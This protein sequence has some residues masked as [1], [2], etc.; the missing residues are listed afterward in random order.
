MNITEALGFLREATN[1]PEADFRTDQW[2]AIDRVA[3]QRQKLLLVQRTGWGKSMVYFM[4]TKAIRDLGRGPTIII[5][6][7]LAL[8][9]NQIEAAGRIGIRATSVDSTNQQDWDRITR[10]ILQD[11]Y[12]AILISPERL[13]NDA[14]IDTVLLPIA[15]S[16]GLLVI[17]EAHCISI[18]GHDFR[19]DYR[20]IVNIIT[21][22]PSNMPVLCTTATANNIVVENIQQQ[23]GDIIVRRGPLRRESLILQNI[24]LNDQASRLAWL[25]HIIPTLEGTGIVY[26]LTKRDCDNVARWLNESGIS[27]AAYYAGVTHPDFR[28]TNEYRVYLEDQLLAD[29]FKVIVAT[30]SLGMGYDKPDLH[31]VIHFQTPDSIIG[32][33]QQVGRAGRAIPRAYGVLLAGREDTDIHAYFRKNAFP[34]RTNVETILRALDESDG[35]SIIQLQSLINLTKSQIENVLKYLRA[36][37]PSPVVK[38]GRLWK[39]TAVQFVM[40]EARITRI[41]ELRIAEWRDINSYIDN[42]STCLMNHLGNAL[43]DPESEDCGMCANCN[44]DHSLTVEFPHELGIRAATY[45]LH[46]EIPLHL[47]K[48][49]APDSFPNYGLRGNIPIPLR[50]EVGRILS[51]WGDAGWGH[52]VQHDK[53]ANHFRDELVDAMAEV[54]TDRWNPNPRPQWVTSVPSQRHPELVPDYARRLATK[55]GIPFIDI[56]EKTRENEAQKLQQNRFF[57]C[58]NLDGAFRV[59][60][61]VLNTP[62]LLV[63]DLVDSGWTLT[64][65]SILLLRAGSGPVYPIALG[66][67]SE[68]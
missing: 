63:D 66:S 17:D 4:A 34:N 21:R 10:E 61:G 28:N 31:F 32:Y 48:Q 19:P 62:V 16:V 26:A 29:N 42:F 50:G 54:I 30:T 27:A 18:W 60:E 64:V 55:L 7:L 5:S 56:I 15:E 65:L 67:T 46:A 1:N 24:R 51:R 9:R 11:H 33:Y 2:D 68:N 44:P 57:R 22:M 35:L 47:K 14:F 52:I 6:P 43:N 58:N 13:S 59:N 12:D 39:R 23:I 8:M 25:A 45:L 38:V 53:H 3:N 36:E 41:N 49:V 40:D 20:R 37:S